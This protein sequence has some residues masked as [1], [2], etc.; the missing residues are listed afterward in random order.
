MPCTLGSLFGSTSFFSG[1]MGFFFI[2]LYD[3]VGQFSAIVHPN[4]GIKL[5]THQSSFGRRVSRVVCGEGGFSLGRSF[6]V[7]ATS[8]LRN[9]RNPSSASESTYVPTIGRDLFKSFGF[10]AYP[11]NNTLGVTSNEVLFRRISTHPGKAGLQ[12]SY[13]IQGFLEAPL[14]GFAKLLNIFLQPSVLPFTY[15]STSFCNFKFCICFGKLF[16]KVFNFGFMSFGLSV[17]FRF[18]FLHF[19]HQ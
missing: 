14:L 9:C 18:T 11:I 3:F 8:L 7:V 13:A 1:I 16:P 19:I 17:K 2:F 10:P 6:N 15:F 4:I 5:S 12:F